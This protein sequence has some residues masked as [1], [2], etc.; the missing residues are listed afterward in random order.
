MMFGC[1][2]CP[3]ISMP[4]PGFC[5]KLTCLAPL[6]QVSE[7]PC[8]LSSG[9]PP[10][11]TDMMRMQELAALVGRKMCKCSSGC[12]KFAA[13]RPHHKKKC[14]CNN[15]KPFKIFKGR[16]SDKPPKFRRPYKRQR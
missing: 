16:K 1:S 10:V 2:N 7:D 13:K 8:S 4:M 5:P 6:H 11:I 9:L 12:L 3:E 15:C 14:P